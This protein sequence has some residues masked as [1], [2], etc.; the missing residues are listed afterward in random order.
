MSVYRRQN[1]KSCHG[2]FSQQILDLKMSALGNMMFIPGEN[3]TMERL[4]LKDF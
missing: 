3:F 2:P 1:R 4:E